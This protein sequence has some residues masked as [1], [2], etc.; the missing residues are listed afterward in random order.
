MDWCSCAH[1]HVFVKRFFVL[2]SEAEMKQLPA[3]AYVIVKLDKTHTTRFIQNH[4][5]VPRVKCSVRYCS[6]IKR[7][8]ICVLC[9]AERWRLHPDLLLRCR[10]LGGDLHARHRR[11]AAALP[12]ERGQSLLEETSPHPV[13]LWADPRWNSRQPGDRHLRHGE[14]SS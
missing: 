1:H 4:S 7:S 6:A 9:C 12:D 3:S 14:Q 5:A 11:L 8:D 10:V 2:M 13:L